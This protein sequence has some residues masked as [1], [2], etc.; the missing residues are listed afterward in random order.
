[1]GSEG[2]YMKKC[3]KPCWPIRSKEFCAKLALT[4]RNPL[5]K[6]LKHKKNLK[7]G[8]VPYLGLELIIYVIK[9]QIH[10]ARQG[11]IFW[12]FYSVVTVLTGYSL[13]RISLSFLL[14]LQTILH[15]R[16]NLPFCICF[17]SCCSYRL[18]FKENLLFCILLSFLLF[19]Q[20]IL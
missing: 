16:V 3:P 2:R 5:K 1:M 18:F 19:I 14:F 10:L 8:P 15:L 20:A 6:S 17:H 7:N 11:K 12:F 4:A 13:R 9:S